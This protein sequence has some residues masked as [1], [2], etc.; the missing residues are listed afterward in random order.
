MAVKRRSPPL[1]GPPAVCLHTG[2][3]ASCSSRD[4]LPWYGIPAYVCGCM[5]QMLQ[6]TTHVRS[7]KPEQAWASLSLSKVLA[8][9]ATCRPSVVARRARKLLRIYCTVWTVCTVSRA[10]GKCTGMT[11]HS[12]GSTMLGDFKGPDQRPDVVLRVRQHT[13]TYTHT[14][15]LSLSPRVPL[16]PAKACRHRQ[17]DDRLYQAHCSGTLW[18][19]STSSAVSMPSSAYCRSSASKSWSQCLFRPSSPKGNTETTK[20]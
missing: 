12:H 20:S 6:Q 1:D 7:Y 17:T 19:H 4:T 10:S 15:S 5:E 8:E 11:R 16:P 2:M 9:L 13:H 3:R 18:I 14:F